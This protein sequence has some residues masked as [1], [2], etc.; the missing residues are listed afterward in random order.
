MIHE[1]NSS[2]WEYKEGSWLIA[3]AAAR[4]RFAIGT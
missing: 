2:L 4:V 1:Y 3:K